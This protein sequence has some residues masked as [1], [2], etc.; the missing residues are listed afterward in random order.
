MSSDLEP[1]LP[2]QSRESPFAIYDD[3][4]A[5]LLGHFPTLENILS[6]NRGPFFY[7]GGAYVPRISTCFLT[8]NL[9]PDPDP[10]AVSSGNFKVEITKLEIRDENKVTRDKVRCP[11]RSY[12]AAGAAVHPS[13]ETPSIIICTQGSLYDAAGLVSIEAKRPHKARM[14]LNNFHGKP[15][16]SP[17]EIVSNPVDK[18]VYFIDP[19]YGYDRG[20]RPK[21]RLPGGHLYR[22]HPASGDCRVVA[23]DLKKPAGLAFSPDYR[24]IYVSEHGGSYGG[25]YVFA[26]DIKYSDP[27]KAPAFDLNVMPGIK[28][29][30]NGTSAPAPGSR[31]QPYATPE[32]SPQSRT[33]TLARSSSSSRSPSG[34]HARLHDNMSNH[35]FLASMTNGLRSPASGPTSAPA[36]I[37]PSPPLA[38]AFPYSN[39]KRGT[40]VSNR[41]LVV[42][43]PN[44][45]PS[46]A[47]ATDPVHGYLWLG[48]EEGVEVWHP[49]TGELI[50][51]ILVEEWDSQRPGHERPKMRGVSKVVFTSDSEALLLGG[52]RIWRLRM[53][54]QGVQVTLDLPTPY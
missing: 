43:T 4:F 53:G 18:A 32:S 42:Y 46:G 49:D 2:Q 24:T 30:P 10:W 37:E 25:V 44:I 15:F 40:F 39:R 28:Y 20:L 1:A 22:F 47:I 51:K 54:F 29:T 27:P 35:K 5:S 23:S 12:L 31:G 3:S 36:H 16:N 6:D 33:V 52:E 8:S 17:S 19:A 26:Y 7:G 45:V 34:S 14:I 48:T 13:S 50:G 11:E 41:R 38:T 9:L 21:P